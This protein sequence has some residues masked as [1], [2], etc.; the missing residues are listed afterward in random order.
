MRRYR[1]VSLAK[2]KYH[3]KRVSTLSHRHL[4]LK[5]TCNTAP[6]LA[7]FVKIPFWFLQ[8]RA[9]SSK[10]G[11]ISDQ[12]N[13]RSSDTSC[14][15]TY[16]LTLEYAHLPPKNTLRCQ[17]HAI[18]CKPGRLSGVLGCPIQPLQITTSDHNSRIHKFRG[19]VT[20]ITKFKQLIYRGI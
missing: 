15:R 9:K 1:I 17:L 8:N 2:S 12:S 10:S 5:Q 13:E 14:G 7:V 11:N 18:H 6:E 16:Q 4:R 19:R 3:N 20:N